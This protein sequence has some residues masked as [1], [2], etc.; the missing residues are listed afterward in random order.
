MRPP[1]TL[2]V[3]WDCREQKELMFPKRFTW[4]TRDG[5]PHTSQVTTTK[6][7]LPSGDYTIKTPGMTLVKR[8]K[9]EYPQPEPWSPL[10]L[11][12]RK[13]S[14]EELWK[15]LMTKDR[16]RELRKWDRMK[17]E[18]P[19]VVLFLDLRFGLRKSTYC[20]EPAATVDRLFRECV[21]RKM[22]VLSVPPGRDPYVSG[23]ILLRWLWQRVYVESYLRWRK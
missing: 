16:G 9:L 14:M 17:E 2:E 4:Y 18:C 6:C 8:P 5:R 20:P 11:A 7:T 12:E 19:A 1:R 21:M 13:G 15:N 23:E 10:V 3:L 22:D